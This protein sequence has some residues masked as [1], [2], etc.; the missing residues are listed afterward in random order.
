VSRSGARLSG[1]GSLTSSDKKLLSMVG[2]VTLI[3]I[4]LGIVWTY[5]IHN[6]LLHSVAEHSAFRWGQSLMQELDL[7]QVFETGALT[8]EQQSDFTLA[9]PRGDI[10]RYKLYNA[11][12]VIFAA[13]RPKDIGRNTTSPAFFDVVAK[14]NPYVR[15]KLNQFDDTIPPYAEVFLPITDGKTFKGALKIYVN[16]S[17][18]VASFANSF[19][20]TSIGLAALLATSAF[21][22]WIIIYRNI[23]ARAR[24]EA[25]LRDAIE[26]ISEG[27]LLY[28]ADDRLVLCNSRYRELFSG[29]ADLLVPGATFEQIIRAGALRGQY[30]QAEGRIEEWI[31]ER[32]KQHRELHVSI[33]RQLSNGRWLKITETRTS[34][35]STVGIRTDITDL[36]KREQELRRSE[37]RLNQVVNALQ[38]GFVLYDT[39]DR[40]VMWNKKWIE[41]HD[42]IADVVKV[43]VP[44][45][46]ILRVSVARNLY[47]DAFGREEEFIAGRLAQHN[48]PSDP[49]IRKLHDGRWYIIREAPTADGGVFA[50]SIDITDLKNAENAA[51]QARM[52]AEEASRAKSEFLANM[53]HELRTPLNAVIG[54]SEAIK[55]Q[56]KTNISADNIPGYI[57]AI[58]SSGRY[59][60]DL[61][62]DLL[63]FSKIEAGKLELRDA[64]VDLG[65]L[66]HELEAL[67]SQNVEAAGLRL[68]LPDTANLPTVVADDI[69][70]R[71]ILLN[72]LSNAIKFTPTGGEITVSVS[73]DRQDG[74]AIAI[75]DTGVGMS[76]ADLALLGEPFRQFGKAQPRHQSGTGLGVSLAK[77]LAEMHG[78]RIDYTSQLGGGTTATLVLPARRVIRTVAAAH[79]AGD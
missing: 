65:K 2:I 29:I 7:M 49:I 24:A 3:G 58:H 36:K 20:L 33:E 16:V 74:L 10:F 25:R 67:V 51:Q 39:D 78:A 42:E 1:L 15:T 77:A 71:Q 37:E 18:E 75:R 28:D 59:L 52:Q 53:S 5:R 43:G 8:Q 56:S 30:P 13:S 72:L 44:F 66:L 73:G 79:S 41:L 22:A 17:R 54:F 12:G 46:R 32:L 60:L 14:G 6:D 48:N 11:R 45:E 55:Q 31:A 68:R 64:D 23:V 57:E 34:D 50:V 62:N 76:K 47:P 63:D 40:L 9:T 4:A 70:L 38:D 27:F 26:S 69:R 35:G 19:R 61:I 21:F